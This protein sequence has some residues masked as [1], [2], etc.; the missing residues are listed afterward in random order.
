MA[1]KG[2]SEMKRKWLALVFVVLPLMAVVTGLMCVADL[3]GSQN[4][5]GLFEPA[6]AAAPEAEPT[7]GNMVRHGRL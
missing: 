1:P 3:T 5:S 4:L 7:I 6:W 2:G